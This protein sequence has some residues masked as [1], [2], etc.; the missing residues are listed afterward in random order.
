MG[1][2]G[3]LNLGSIDRMQARGGTSNYRE[4]DR[5]SP[6]S[7][8]NIIINTLDILDILLLFLLLLWYTVD[9]QSPI[10]KGAT[11][12]SA[13]AFRGQHPSTKEGRNTFEP[14]IQSCLHQRPLCHDPE[15]S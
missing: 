14:H 4:A 13:T 11:T 6:R 3:K 10:R 12:S 2:H 15:D 1:G 5:P 8:Q 9:R 7:N